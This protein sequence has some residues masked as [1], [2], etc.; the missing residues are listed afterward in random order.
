MRTLTAEE[1]EHVSGADIS[2]GLVGVGIGTISGL[3]SGAIAGAVWGT[4]VGG[5]VGTGVGAV[6]GVGYVLATEDS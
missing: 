5:L 4:A 6:A 1:I 3:G 2:A